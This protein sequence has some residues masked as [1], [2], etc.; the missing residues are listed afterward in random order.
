MNIINETSQ[1]VKIARGSYE[2]DINLQIQQLELIKQQQSQEIDEVIHWLKKGNRENV[3]ADVCDNLFFGL[4]MLPVLNIH[5]QE[6][7][8]KYEKVIES[9]W[10]KYCKTLKEA[11]ETVRAYSN[12]T[13]PDKPGVKLKTIFIQKGDYYIIFFLDNEDQKEYTDWKI[14]KSI[15]FIRED[16]L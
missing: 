11:E 13:H 2:S 9:N 4:N 1:W 8:S 12:G 16:K 6:F 14:A 5:P 3:I 15:N 7:I 10:T